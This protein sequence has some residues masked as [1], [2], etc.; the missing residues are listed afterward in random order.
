MSLT[1]HNL[2][3]FLK[4][5]KGVIKRD[6][7]HPSVITWVP[8]NERAE[9]S[10]NK[11]AQEFAKSVYSE[12]KSMDATRPVVDTSGWTHVVTD[13]YDVHDYIYSSQTGTLYSQILADE[14]WKSFLDGT[15]E[16]DFGEEPFK[17]G[18]PSAYSNQP[19]IIS[20]FGGW[21]IENQKPIVA[22]PRYSYMYVPDSF[23]L[24][25]K[26]RDIVSAIAMAQNISGYCYTQLYDVEGEINGLLTYDRVWK[27]R[28]SII[29]KINQAAKEKWAKLS[30][31]KK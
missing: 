8:L 17:I 3:I 9:I 22:R 5:W 2:P 16:I 23:R 14:E 20:E 4:Q 31:T 26:F 10:N 6:L 24:E 12:T 15:E 7:N 30:L 11:E 18:L 21:G 13:I 25:S 29:K 28:S 1:K 27:V 19:V